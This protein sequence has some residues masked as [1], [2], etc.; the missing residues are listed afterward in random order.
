MPSRFAALQNEDSSD[1][2]VSSQENE[3]QQKR[4]ESQHKEEVHIPSY[5]DLSASRADEE[6]V[7][8]AVYGEDFQRH[9]GV[10]GYPRLEVK[11]FPPDVSPERIGSKLL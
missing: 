3:A 8:A 5:E 10:W 2:D 1:D 4:H 6:T 9:R 11:V 7:L